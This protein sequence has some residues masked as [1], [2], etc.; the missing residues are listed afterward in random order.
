LIIAYGLIAGIF[1]Y[2]LL[3]GGAWIITKASGG[4]IKPPGIEEADPWTY[5]IEGGVLPPWVKRAARGKKD[6]WRADEEHFGT[7][8][9]ATEHE[10]TSESSSHEPV[11]KT[12]QPTKS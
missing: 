6:F 9:A 4:K 8:P 7:D 10:R 12:A 5:K 3:N 11:E 2:T 1:T